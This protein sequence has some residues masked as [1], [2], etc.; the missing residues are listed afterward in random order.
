MSYDTRPKNC[1]FR[2]QDEGKPYSRSSCSSCKRSIM[3]G[4]SASCLYV[5]SASDAR[6][7]EL[8]AEVERLRVQS[9]T[10]RN[11]LQEADKRIVWEHHGLGHDFTDRVEDALND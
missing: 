8:E 7:A 5:P 4:I 10:M 3:T 9:E 1:R 11:I 6:I 2:L